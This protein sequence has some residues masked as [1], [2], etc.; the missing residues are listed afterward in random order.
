MAE[1]HFLQIRE[2]LDKRKIVYEHLI[3]EH[4]HHSEDAA[5]IRGTNLSEAAKAIILKVEARDRSFSFIQAVRTSLV[6]K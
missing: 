6:I 2:L 4:V 3:H 1:S 5:K